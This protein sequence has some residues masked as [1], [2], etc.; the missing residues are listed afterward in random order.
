MVGGGGLVGGSGST[1]E[2]PRNGMI[3]FLLLDVLFEPRNIE[4]KK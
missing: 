2:P 4:I 3:P 1:S